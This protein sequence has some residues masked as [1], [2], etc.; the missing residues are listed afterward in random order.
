MPKDHELVEHVFIVFRDCPE[1]FDA[2]TPVVD[3]DIAALRDM[4]Q[5]EKDEFLARLLEFAGAHTRRRPIDEPIRSGTLL[6]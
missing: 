6:L 5:A 3:M 2:P 4:S 1:D